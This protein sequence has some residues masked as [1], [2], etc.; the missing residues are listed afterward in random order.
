LPVPHFLAVLGIF[1]LVEVAWCDGSISPEERRAVLDA[2]ADLGV[3][4]DSPTHQ[5]LD[6]WLE[7]RPAENAVDLWADYTRAICATL[8]PGMVAKVKDGVMGRAKK[9]AMAAG[10]ILG[11]GNRIS[12]VEQDCLDDLAKAFEPAATKS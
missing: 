7:H 2:A 11:F 5:L 1:P 9:I 3:A 8:D 12:P 10:G 6:R 4:K